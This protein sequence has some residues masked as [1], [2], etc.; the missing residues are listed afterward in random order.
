MKSCVYLIVSSLTLLQHIESENHRNF[1]ENDEN[2][3]ALD[4][5]LSRLV[6]MPKRQTWKRD[7]SWSHSSEHDKF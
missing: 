6:R 1:A 7:P 2:W 5:L 3:V 4:D